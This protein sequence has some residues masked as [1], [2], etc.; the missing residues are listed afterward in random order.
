MNI[1]QENKV[2]VFPGN[3]SILIS[4][5]DDYPFK[6]EVGGVIFPSVRHAV[7]EG[8]T[9]SLEIKQ[10][11]ARTTFSSDLFELSNEIIARPKWSKDFA[12][13]SLEKFSMIRFNTDEKARKI[14]LETEPNGFVYQS[15]QGCS[16]YQIQELIGC[17]E[18]ILKRVRENLLK[19]NPLG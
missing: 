15:K 5:C 6:I 17:Y 2:I 4:L 13:K 1:L 7:L 3:D 16:L 19:Q 12:I 11:I 14:L 8:K 9:R 18:K 10:L